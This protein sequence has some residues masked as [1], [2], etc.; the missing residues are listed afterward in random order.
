MGQDRINELN[1]ALSR[2]RK[3]RDDLASECHRLRLQREDGFRDQLPNFAPLLT[4]IMR[5]EKERM[6]TLLSDQGKELKQA[7]EDLMEA[8]RTF[9]HDTMTWANFICKD[10]GASEGIPLSGRNRSEGELVFDEEALEIYDA[11]EEAWTAVLG[12]VGEMNM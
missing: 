12:A 10:G 2:V 6:Q 1:E 9:E 8:F 11:V 5:D 3:D 4:A 7:R